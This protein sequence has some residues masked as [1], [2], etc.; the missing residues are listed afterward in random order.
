MKGITKD[1]KK[2]LFA[3]LLKSR[4]VEEK[5]IELI[6]NS[7]IPGGWLHPC[8]GQEAI[9]I[10]VGANL[11]KTDYIN[12]THR[13]RSIIIG[14]GVPLKRFML[15]VLGRKDG[16]CG[17]IAGE[18]HYCDAEYGI[19]GQTVIIGAVIPIAVGIAL[20]CK[21][22]NT[23]QIVVSIFGDGA[24]DEGNFHEGMNMASLWKLPI[25]FI[26]ENNGWAQFTPQKAS[27][28][29]PEIWRKAEGYKMP[30]EVADGMDLLEVYETAGEAIA[31]ARR[32]EGPTLI[33]YR[34]NRWLGHYVGDP[35]KYRDPKDIEEARKIDPVSGFQK[36]LLDEGILTIEDIEKVE[37]S[38][39]MEIEEALEFAKNSPPAS[40]E[41]AFRNVYI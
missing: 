35:Q 3:L 20:A 28:A 19:V 1:K 36:R 5:L 21:Y 6:T 30:G 31:R 29:Q 13:G 18:M 33:E 2:E 25:V 10:G 8:L 38:T 34:V 22:R 11:K 24:V 27:A 16:P 40:M 4:R 15:E 9:G 32:G 23:D 17:G 26:A 39:K 7:E 12:N 14:K 37:K 41:Q